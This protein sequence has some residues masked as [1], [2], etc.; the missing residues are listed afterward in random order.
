[1]SF[2]IVPKYSV[3]CEYVCRTGQHGGRGR[4]PGMKWI[5]GSGMKGVALICCLTVAWTPRVAAQQIPTEA[6]TH[7]PRV[8]VVLSGGGV[9]GFAHVGALR[10][11]EDAGLPVDVVTGTS[12]GSFIGGLYAIGYSVNQIDSLLHAEDWQALFED[13]SPRRQQ[14]LESRITDEGVLLSLPLRGGQVELPKSIVSG[15]RISQILSRLMFPA[16]DVRDFNALPVPFGALAADLANGDGV[17]LEFGPPSGRHQ[18]QHIYPK[19]L[20][21]GCDRWPD[22]D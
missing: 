14:T 18:G 5:H 8:G 20:R 6:E 16:W 15:Q 21:P 12:M 2:V 19:Y 13:D 22:A 4:R 1:M 9:K 3:S 10:V 11:I 7:V 17:L